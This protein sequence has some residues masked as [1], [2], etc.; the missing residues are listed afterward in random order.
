MSSFGC[1]ASS[2][3]FSRYAWPGAPAD[4]LSYDQ[5]S[6]RLEKP[7]ELISCIPAGNDH[8]GGR[9]K[10]GPDRMLYYTLG[11]QGHNQFGNFCK[12]IE[13]RRLPTQQEVDAKD[14]SR[15][16]REG[17]PYGSARRHPCRQPRDQ[18][19][20]QSHRDLAIHPNNRTFYIPID[21]GGFA[22]DA[23]GGA[24]ASWRTR[25]LSWSSHLLARA[26]A[27]RPGTATGQQR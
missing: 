2:A 9:L 18:G 6:G 23:G 5:K 21:N 25:D 17:A 22:R 8:N 14:W 10:I 7:T 15:I 19:C 11:E 27:Q 3:P 24:T 4:Q 20:P 1:S 13:A 12:P 16:H 26:E